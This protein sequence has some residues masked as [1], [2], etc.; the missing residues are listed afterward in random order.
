MYMFK[1]LHIS[2]FLSLFVFSGTALA[3]TTTNVL[4][5][6]SSVVGSCFIQSVVDID[7]GTYDPFDQNPTEAQGKV[8]V[9]CIKETQYEILISANR[10]MS[11]GAD[12]LLNYELYLELQVTSCEL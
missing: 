5:V 2:L 8:T 6:L 11:L 3:G 9:A 4:N 7:F 1:Q 12:F 10:Q